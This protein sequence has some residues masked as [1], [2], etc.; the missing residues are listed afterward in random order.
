MKVNN[1]QDYLPQLCKLY[2]DIDPADIKR[3]C[4][5]GWKSVY[6]HNSYGGD[7]I[8]NNQDFWCYMGKLM[9]DSLKFFD[10]YV[11]KLCTKIQV[12]HRRLKIPWD[13]YYYFALTD[14]QYENY[15]QQINSK[16][17]KRKKFSFQKLLLY[18]IYEECSINEHNNRYIFKVRISTDVGYRFYKEE[19]I[20]ESPELIVKREPLTFKDV[21][22]SNN[23]YKYI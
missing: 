13:G 19:A 7:V 8:I 3:I 22:I 4:T 9:K 15:L 6:L 5:F 12:I 20:L 1:L 23:N 16:G 17:R 21:L 11:M 14:S 10:Y 2:P 18:K